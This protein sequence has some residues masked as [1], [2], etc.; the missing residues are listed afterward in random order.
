MKFQCS[1]CQYV[2]RKDQAPKR[3]PYCGEEGKMVRA[4]DA[5]DLINDALKS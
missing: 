1:N 4:K 5:Q 2:V 3:C